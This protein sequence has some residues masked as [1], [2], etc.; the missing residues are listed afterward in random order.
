MAGF[1]YNNA[2]NTST[3]H[4]S[5]ELNCDYHLRVSYKEDIN[6]RSRS[7]SANEFSIELRELMTVYK[8]NF[9]HAQELQK[10]AHEKAVKP[11][12][13]VPG[14][15]VWLNSKYIKTKQNR[16]LEA[17]FFKLF[18]VLH[19][20]GNQAYKLELPKKWRIHDV[21]YV[22]LLKHNNTRKGRVDEITTQLKFEVGD[23]GEEYKVEAI[24]DSVV[25]A[26][27]SEGHLPGLYYL[28]AW[29]CYPE[30]EN[31]WEPALVVQHL[32]KLISTFN[33]DHPKKPIATSLPIDTASPWPGQSADLRPRPLNKNAADQPKPTTLSALKR[34]KSLNFYLVFGPVSPK[35]KKF[36]F[37]ICFR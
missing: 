20:V 9:H 18:Q 23:N 6:P 36:F 13:Y 16:K 32:W 33:K 14:N 8:E 11:R 31:T 1:A 7:K 3:G 28:V 21:F 17:K 37:V 12:S 10:Q 22:S 27:K 29:I 19:L 2:K 5:F 24:W 35:S 4:T 26:R 25:Y 30:K 34:A 15:K